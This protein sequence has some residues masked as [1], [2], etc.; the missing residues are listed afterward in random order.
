M[1]YFNNIT[2]LSKAK[3]TFKTLCKT[4]HPDTSGY[5]SQSDFIQMHNQFKDLTNK[6]KFNTGF[7]SD[8]EFDGDK[9]YDLVKKF[10]GLENIK[11]S[12]V[13]CFIWLEDIVTGAMYQQKEL[14]KAIKIDGYNSSR[15]AG[16]KKMWYFS[17][18]G[19]KQMYK[20]NKTIDQIKNKYGS[21]EFKTKSA[22]KLA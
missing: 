21:N 16:K 11:V 7:E 22:Y 8:K 15:W 4:L 2:E 13:G 1:N 9:F 17:K 12:F 10:E 5:D 3:E 6:L 14:I 20:S 19:Y 18:E